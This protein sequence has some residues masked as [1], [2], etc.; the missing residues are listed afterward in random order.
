MTDDL[1]EFQFVT[2]FVQGEADL[3]Q[4]AID[5]ITQKRN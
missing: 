2:Q 1:R 4:G 3:Q 5:K